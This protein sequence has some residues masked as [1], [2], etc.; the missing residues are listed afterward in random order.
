MKQILFRGAATALVT[1]MQPDGSLDLETLSRLTEWQIQSSISALVPCGTTGE[2]ATLTDEERFTVIQTV[3][4]TAAGRVPVIAGA[5]CNDTARAEQNCLAAAAAGADA[6]LLVTPYYNKCTP[7]GLQSHFARLAS[8]TPL[9]VIL[10]NVPS[11]TGVTIDMESR[12]KLSK[13]DNIIGLKELCGSAFKNIGLGR[14]LSAIVD[15]TFPAVLNEYHVTNLK[16]GQVERRDSNAPLAALV[17]KT[18][19]DPF[20]GRMSFVRVFSG[21][22]KADSTVYNASRDEMEKVGNINTLRGK[23]PLP[24][25]QIV[26]GDIGVISRLQFTMTG[27]TLSAKEE[28]VQFA[29]IEYPLPMY[30]RA[31]S[32]KKKGDED[33]IA[34]ALGKLMDEDPTFIVSRNPVTKE[35]L[36]SGMGDQHLEILMERMKRKFGVDAVLKPPMVEYRETIRGSAEVEGKYK[37]QTGGHGQYGHVVIKM[38][39]LPPGSGF[40]FVDK[41]FGGAVPRQYIPA[42]EKG[43]KESMEHGILAGYPVVDLKITLLD[44]SYHTVDSS[45]MAFKVAS[46]MAFQKAAEQSKP[47]LM[48]PYYNLDVYCDE[49]MTGDIISDLNGKRGR[50]LGM[51]SAEDGRAVVKAQVPYA[52]ILD[53]A[54]DLRALTQGTGTFEM[55]FDHYEDVPPKLAEKIVADGH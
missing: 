49:R 26:A 40:E 21:I 34:A 27:D 13:V 9:P 14:T 46:H 32:P 48:E 29:P 3:A 18:T 54:V 12:R 47:V 15:Y 52:E 50:I 6:L 25:K 30:S 2:A 1:P 33:K 4:K 10:Y 24:M 38:E 37:K 19:S 31:I 22:I 41:I 11:R 16:T 36:I 44:G 5:G 55:K 23:N 20:V 45:E 8:A 7:K 35:T 51:Q 39:P 17:F 42:V 53:Y 43:M 28:P